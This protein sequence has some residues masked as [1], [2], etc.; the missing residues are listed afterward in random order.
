MAM[1]PRGP[2]VRDV[3]AGWLP[4][5]SFYCCFCSETIHHEDVV[6]GSS[7]VDVLTL[8]RF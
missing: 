5:V 1:G 7:V 6:Q 3:R 4:A 2:D 8:R